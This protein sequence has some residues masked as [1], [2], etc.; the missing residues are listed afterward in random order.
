MN[1][2]TGYSKYSKDHVKRKKVNSNKDLYAPL[3][4]KK[5]DIIYADPPW[6]YNNKLQFDKSSKSKEKID[7]NKKIFISSAEFKYPVLRLEELKSL[8]VKNISKDD[9]LL[10][11]W[12]TNPH[13]EQAIQLGTAWGFEYKTIIFIWNKLV[14]NPGQY[15]LSYCEVC[16]LFKRGR[17]PQPRGARNIKQYFEE[18]R[19]IHSRKPS[20]AREN[21]E[22]MFP[23]QKRIEL[24]SR[25]K[26]KGWDSWGLDA[27]S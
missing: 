13:L 1:K 23:S 3:P 17:I 25:E 16:L 2:K 22:L 27:K 6:F 24:F 19:T 10:F 21:I 18:K 8:D 14:H 11:M 7:L 26:I 20:I 5:Y 15:N 4:K 9:C 12:S